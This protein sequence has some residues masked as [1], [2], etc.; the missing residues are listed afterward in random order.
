MTPSEL[1]DQMHLACGVNWLRQEVVDPKQKHIKH[2]YSYK[3]NTKVALYLQ[4]IYDPH[5]PLKVSNNIQV[6]VQYR[7]PEYANKPMIIEIPIAGRVDIPLSDEMWLE[8][9]KRLSPE[10]VKAWID[11]LEYAA[12]NKARAH[13]IA[14]N[15]SHKYREIRKQK[16]VTV[17]A[18]P[19]ENNPSEPFLGMSAHFDNLTE[20][21]LFD[22]IELINKWCEDNKYKS[23]YDF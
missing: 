19:N 13:K 10:I 21:Q 16:F 5:D 11:N 22:I 8:I 15:I 9:Q 7:V 14:L 3:F 12:K 6:K 4:T 2:R 17:S 23:G 20:E 18:T 1:I